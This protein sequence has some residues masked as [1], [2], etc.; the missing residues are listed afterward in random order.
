VF[1][2]PDLVAMVYGIGGIVFLVGFAIGALTTLARVVYYSI[3]RIRRPRLLTRD[4][5]VWGGLALSFAQIASVRFLP[6]D[7]R[8]LFTTGNV[9]WALTTTIPAVVAVVTYCYF[10]LWVIERTKVE[11]DP[12][13]LESSVQA[14]IELTREGIVHAQS[15]SDKA[16]AAYHEANT[17]NEKIATLTEALGHK[18]DQS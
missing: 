7:V 2:N 11:P 13:A 17:V 10:E 16:D 4:V 9:V 14:N 5:V 3:H 8:T 18:Q 12:L 15:A 1:N 6:S